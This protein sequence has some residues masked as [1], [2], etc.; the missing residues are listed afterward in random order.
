M[1]KSPECRQKDETFDEC[2]AR[3]IPEIM[4]ENPDMD[5]DQAVAIAHSMCEEK[6]S[7]KFIRLL[8]EFAGR[9]D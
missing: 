7:D 4:E 2:V 9:N 1:K 3:K 6:C 5:Q 8:K